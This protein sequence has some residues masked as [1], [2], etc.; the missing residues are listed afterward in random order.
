MDDLIE[1]GMVVMVA[2]GSISAELN[3]HLP[4]VCLAVV[5]DR[6]S[7]THWWLEI[8]V[9]P[10]APALLQMYRPEEI[11]GIPARGITMPTGPDWAPR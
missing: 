1:S 9:G 4:M 8:A 6:A 10:H 3:H 11:L 7:A 5:R 2:A